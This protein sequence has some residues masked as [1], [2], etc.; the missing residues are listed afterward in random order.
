[1]WP[2]SA[3]RA[4]PGR[5]GAAELRG[6]TRRAARDR[7]RLRDLELAASGRLD[8]TPVTT[9]VVPWEHAID[10]LLRGGL[11]PVIV[12]NALTG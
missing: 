6:V 3:V 10:G 4:W 7:D 2:G 12:R 9:A 11:K 5:F 1:M 8:P